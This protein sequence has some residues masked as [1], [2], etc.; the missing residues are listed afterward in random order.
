MGLNLKAI[1]LK[2]RHVYGR[3]NSMQG[4]SKAEE[5]AKDATYLLNS[6]LNI[7]LL[8]SEFHLLPTKFFHRGKYDSL[9]L[10]CFLE[11]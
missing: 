4:E 7:F 6:E 10:N 5:D 11:E 1:L 3:R 8:L 9:K 2:R